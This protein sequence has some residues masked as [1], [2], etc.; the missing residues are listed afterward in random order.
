MIFPVKSELT[1]SMATISAESLLARIMPMMRSR[2]FSM[3]PSSLWAG[4][5]MEYVGENGI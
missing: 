3:V 2:N 1:S 5:T 4:V